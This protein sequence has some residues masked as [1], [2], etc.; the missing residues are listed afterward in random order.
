MHFD[1]DITKFTIGRVVFYTALDEKL[2]TEKY[3][4]TKVGHVIG[5]GINSVNEVLVNVKFADG[6]Q[7]AYHPTVLRV[8]P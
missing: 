6:Y 1:A 5:F 7:A 8:N 2:P 4:I 3:P